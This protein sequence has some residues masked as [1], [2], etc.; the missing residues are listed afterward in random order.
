MHPH[1]SSCCLTACFISSHI[2]G[3][4]KHKLSI[5][6]FCLQVYE[7]SSMKADILRL[8]ALE[9][10]HSEGGV[11]IIGYSMFCLLVKGSGKRKKKAVLSR[12][13]RVL[14]DPGKCLLSWEQLCLRHGQL[15]KMHTGNQSMYNSCSTKP[16]HDWTLL[17]TRT[18]CSERMLRCT[19]PRSCEL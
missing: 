15:Y 8:E 12:Y 10:W 9:R 19:I 17:V 1:F 13:R 11:A 2:L 7:V 18:N 5:V 14:L 16:A 3:S 6:L 4:A